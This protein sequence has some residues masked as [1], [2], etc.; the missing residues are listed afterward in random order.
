M[1][2]LQELRLIEEHLQTGRQAQDEITGHFLYPSAQLSHLVSF[3]M[4]AQSGITP[5]LNHPVVYRKEDIMSQQTSTTSLVE[6]T[7]TFNDN[8]YAVPGGSL[9]VVSLQSSLVIALLEQFGVHSCTFTIDSVQVTFDP[10]VTS[11]VSMKIYI[12]AVID[13]YA[14]RNPV[15]MSFRR[16]RREIFTR[17]T[18]RYVTR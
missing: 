15:I 5:E 16:G 10:E 12:D 11:E 7:M 1:N 17:T 13:D 9:E 18:T 8:L 3:V 2:I 6:L 4:G 14:S